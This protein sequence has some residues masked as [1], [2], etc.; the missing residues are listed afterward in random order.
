[1]NSKMW[2]AIILG[3][4]SAIRVLTTWHETSKDFSSTTTL[5]PLHSL[6]RWE[7]CGKNRNSFFHC[8]RRAK[9]GLLLRRGANSWKK[10]GKSFWHSNMRLCD[11][12]E[13]LKTCRRSRKRFSA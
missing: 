5:C 10:T 4:L 9:D 12:L 11:W 3:F 13:N 8:C 2:Q 1:M 7:V 6:E